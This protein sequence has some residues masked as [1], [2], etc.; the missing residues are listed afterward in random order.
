VSCLQPIFAAI[1]LI[2]AHWLSA[3]STNLLQADCSFLAIGGV[4][5]NVGIRR[6]PT[7]WPT[8]NVVPHLSSTSIAAFEINLLKQRKPLIEAREIL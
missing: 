8:A 3:P 4:A 7:K 2:A 1:K 5:P 6:A